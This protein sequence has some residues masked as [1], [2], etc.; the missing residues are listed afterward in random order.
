VYRDHVTAVPDGAAGIYH[1]NHAL[2]EFRQ[3]AVAEYAQ[4]KGFV[5]GATTRSASRHKYPCLIMAKSM[6]Y[7]A[8]L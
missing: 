1:D 4:R 5:L 2:L 6:I 8:Q 3:H 7:I